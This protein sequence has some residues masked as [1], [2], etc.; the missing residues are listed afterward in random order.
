MSKEQFLEEKQKD[1][2]QIEAI[3]DAIFKEYPDGMYFDEFVQFNEK[4]SSEL[5]YP[6]FDCLYD[7]VPCVQNYFVLK[8]NFK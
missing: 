6:I 2:D 8:A 7:L 4:V 1:W 3:A 5:F